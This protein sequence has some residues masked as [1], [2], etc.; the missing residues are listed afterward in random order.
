MNPRGHIGIGMIISVNPYFP[1]LW[2]IGTPFQCADKDAEGKPNKNISYFNL[3]QLN[4]RVANEYQTEKHLKTSSG[5][6][7]SCI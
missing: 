6:K 7:C 4:S 5:K 3:G 2:Q 1:G